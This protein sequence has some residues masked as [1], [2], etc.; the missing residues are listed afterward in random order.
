M[1]KVDFFAISLPK[2]NPI[3]YSGENL[4]GSVLIRIKE[5][6]KINCVRLLIKGE[7]RVHWTET[8]SSGKT[9]HTRH[10]NGYETYLNVDLVLVAKQPNLDLVLTPGDYTYPFSII[11]PSNLPTC[12]EH[13]YGRIRYSL[14]GTIN[15][16]WALDKHTTRSFTVLNAF[17][18]NLYPSLRVSYAMNGSKTFCCLFCKSEPILAT[19]T[20]KKSNISYNL[21]FIYSLNGIC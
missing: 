10:Y 1:G 2:Q 19:M 11:L 13:V 7:A 9:R 6:L 15:I 3:Y 14:N 20:A 4:N 5:N 16:P 21:Y 18:L 17:D 8:Q 12:F